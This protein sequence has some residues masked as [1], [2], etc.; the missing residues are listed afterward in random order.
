MIEKIMIPK[1]V[2]EAIELYLEDGVNCMK[3]NL[4]VR[5]SILVAEHCGQD[6]TE[7]EI[8]QYKALNKISTYDLMRCLV[9]GYE[10]FDEQ[11]E[12]ETQ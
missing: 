7:Y 6:W 4:E 2:S 1:D 9:N 11:S 8:G 3:R 10:V 12:T 5:K